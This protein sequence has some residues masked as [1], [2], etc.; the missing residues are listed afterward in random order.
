MVGDGSYRPQALFEI[1]DL[2]FLAPADD[3]VS[4]LS[5]LTILGKFSLSA[6]FS[7]QVFVMR[8]PG[9]SGSSCASVS[10]SRS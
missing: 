3:I 6:S 10:R 9:G 5:S 7:A 8:P 1:S 4:F 2:E